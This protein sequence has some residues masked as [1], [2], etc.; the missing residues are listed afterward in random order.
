ML[1]WY[2]SD[3]GVN[4]TAFP[5][6]FLNFCTNESSIHELLFFDPLESI[7]SRTRGPSICIIDFCEVVMFVHD[8]RKSDAVIVLGQCTGFSNKRPKQE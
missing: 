4:I 3:S 6:L 2:P 1:A 8:A 7:N 5:S